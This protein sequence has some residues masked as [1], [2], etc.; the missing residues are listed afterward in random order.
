MFYGG[1]SFS[2][3]SQFQQVVHQNAVVATDVHAVE[4]LDDLADDTLVGV[5]ADEG[6]REGVVEGKLRHQVAHPRVEA[7]VVRL[8]AVQGDVRQMVGAEDVRHVW[9]QRLPDALDVE[10]AELLVPL[11]N[12]WN[13]PILPAVPWKKRVVLAP[14]HASIEEEA[15][16]H[17]VVA[18][19]FHGRLRVQDMDVGRFDSLVACLLQRLL[20]GASPELVVAERRQNRQFRGE[21]AAEEGV[22]ADDKRRR[23]SVPSHH[24]HVW[25][26]VLDQIPYALQ[27]RREAP[28][29]N[30][31]RNIGHPQMQV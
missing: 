26:G 25:L 24:G 16:A 30:R 27:E 28:L 1:N 11:L 17:E 10:G 29:V 7:V 20:K 9:L 22:Q 18:A 14:A 13:S 12:V 23:H 15:S 6:V 8:E 31:I 19:N 21:Q 4:S 5:S 3:F 2:L